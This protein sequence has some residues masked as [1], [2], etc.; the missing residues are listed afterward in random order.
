MPKI[1]GDGTVSC[2][3]EKYDVCM[4]QNLKRHMLNIT[5]SKNGCTTP[6]VL[7]TTN[8]CNENGNIKGACQIDYERGKN[9][10]NEC[11]LPCE[12]LKISLGDKDYSTPYSGI[13]LELHFPAKILLTEEKYLYNFINLVAEIGGLIGL[14][15]NMFWIV[16]L[17]LGYLSTIYNSRLNLNKNL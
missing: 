17:L 16:M 4:Y 14:V 12:T 5:R 3:N 9:Q 10:F 11:K 1:Q 2:S 15:R 7:N 13:N 8:I 6:W